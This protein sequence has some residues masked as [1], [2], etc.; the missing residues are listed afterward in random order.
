MADSTV[1][2]E[3]APRH[4]QHHW[5]DSTYSVR[6]SPYSGIVKA[7]LEAGLAAVDPYRAVL[8][9]VHIDGFHLHIGTQIYDLEKYRRMVLGGVGKAAFPMAVALEAILGDR[10]ETGIIVTKD[11]YA[12]N[13]GVSEQ[14]LLRKTQVYVSGHPVPDERGVAAAAQISQLL[15]SLTQNDLVIFLISGGGSALLTSPAQGISLTDLQQFTELMLRSGADI[16]QLNTLRK[17]LDTVKGGGL[18]RLAA[19][20]DMATLILSDVIGD[21]I[22]VI[23]SGPTVQDTSTFQ[24]AWSIIEQYDLMDKV[25][26]SIDQHLD[27]GRR[28]EILDTLN[29]E[30]WFANQAQPLVIAGNYQ[31]ASAAAAQAKESGLNTILLTSFLQGEAREVGRVL[32]ALARQV[33]VTGEPV[34]RPACIVAGGETTV[35]V[36]GTGLG[37]R[38][39]ELALGSLK[40]LANL[41]RT[42][43]V[44]LTTDGGDG[45]TDAAGAAVTGES[46]DR[47]QKSGLNPQKYLSQNDAYH[48]F[49]SLGDLLR[50]G[51]TQTNANDLALLFM[52]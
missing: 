19:P 26:D 18:A 12:G 43:L 20:A 31:A 22:D 47:A 46:L 29:P 36:R 48:F 3:S 2:S 39:Q 17:H 40:D 28:G 14:Q 6:A 11:G 30:E 24:D 4:L 8:R 33:R 42:L 16:Y 49:E 51:P 9:A 21:P 50:P 37:G 25:P 34:C 52:F 13:Q 1:S 5:L 45:P 23:A 10:L 44:T 15:T 32:A 7:V 27:R 41:S 38:N 35:T